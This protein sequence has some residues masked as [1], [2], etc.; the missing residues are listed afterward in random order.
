MVL[1]FFGF[2]TYAQSQNISGTVN[3][4]DNNPL[5]GISILVKGKK[6]QTSTDGNGKFLINGVDSKDVLVFSYVGFTTQEIAVGNKTSLT[7]TLKE[8]SKTLNEIVVV[9]FGVQKKANLTGAVDQVTS[10][11]LENRPITNLT[12]VLQGVMPNLNLKMMDGKPTQS[13]SYNI[14]GTTSIGQ[15]GSALVLIDGFEGDP[16]LLNPNDVE[17]V[18]MLKDAAS[19]AIYGRGEHLV[20]S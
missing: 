18:S 8:D 11:A 17:T 2:S 20:W 5:P 10:E 16:S 12:R 6:L 7:V 4:S 9:G 13:P 1:I 3:D 19:A 15:G 14:R